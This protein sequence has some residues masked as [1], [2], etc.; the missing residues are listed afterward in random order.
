M[1]VD[2]SFKHLD[3]S[4]MLENAIEKNLKKIQ[5]RVKIFKSDEAIHLSLHVEKNPHRS[6]YFAWSNIYMP[7]KVLK[8]HSKN[9]TATK[10][11]NDCFS[12][13]LSQLDKFKHKVESHLRRKS[14]GS[15]KKAKTIE[16]IEL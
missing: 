3:K 12:A 2:V 11:L 9:T 7:S 1:R 10:A 16:D 5:R 13:M 4:P 14:A 8:G 15:L 6:E